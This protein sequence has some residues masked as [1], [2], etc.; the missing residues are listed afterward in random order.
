MSMAYH[1]SAMSTGTALLTWLDRRL[2]PDAMAWLRERCSALAAGAPDRQLFLSFSAASRHT[3]KAELAL[4]TPELTE[5]NGL[6]DGWDPR[7]WTADQAGRIALLRHLPSDDEARYLAALDRLFG[8]ADLGEQVA[9]FKAL[10]LLAFPEAHRARCAEGVRTNMTDVFTAVAHR[11]PYP[12]EQLDAIAWHQVV[13]KALFVGVALDPI[14]G[15]DRRATPQLA[16]MLLD[17][18]HERWSAHRPVS[19]ELWRCVGP[20]ADDEALGDLERVLCDR[21]DPASQRAA[22]LALRACPHPDAAALLAKYAVDL[23]DSFDW[24]QLA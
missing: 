21:G 15:L 19:P 8:A 20:H 9:L 3:G 6:R 13:L 2:A 1:P 23:P 22:T 17:Y 7:S 4:T 12:A 16:R 18:A 14:V 11:N 10:P 5:A 24:S